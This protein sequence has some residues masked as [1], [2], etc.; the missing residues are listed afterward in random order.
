[1]AFDDCENLAEVTILN[2][3]ATIE[4][5]AFSDYDTAILVLYGYN[6][7][8]TQTYA[9][10][11]GFQFIP[12]DSVELS[13]TSVAASQ[14]TVNDGDKINF[15]CMVRNTGNIATEGI[16]SVDF[17]YNGVLFE[18]VEYDESIPAGQ[19][20]VIQTEGEK[21]TFFGVHNIKAIVNSDKTISESDYTNN[22]L[23]SRLVVNDV[24]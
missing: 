12:L 14:S 20:K 10:E 19:F 11:N 9:E 23:K 22:A 7:S 15:Y 18:T 21:S 2:R 13:I 24:A 8:T 6:G 17:Y 5:H 16:I 1:M 3:D 4:K